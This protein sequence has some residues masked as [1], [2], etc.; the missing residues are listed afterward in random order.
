MKRILAIALSTLALGATGAQ[1]T[2][3]APQPS[4]IDY[5]PIEVGTTA[6]HAVAGN[7]AAVVEGNFPQPSF[8]DYA[9]IEAGEAS[10]GSSIADTVFAGEG[11]PQPS[12]AN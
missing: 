6:D 11:F 4:F 9:A 10:T 3:Q 12:F 5:A 2:T 8:V 1:A 7:T